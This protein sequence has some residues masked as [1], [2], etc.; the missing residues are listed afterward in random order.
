MNPPTLLPAF[1]I[2]TVFNTLIE[3][4]KIFNFVYFNTNKAMI[5]QSKKENFLL[6][7]YCFAEIE[8]L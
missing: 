8:W 4:M 2:I 3:K 6:I 1:I 5:K 7:C